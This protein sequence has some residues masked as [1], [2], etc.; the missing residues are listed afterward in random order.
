MNQVNVQPVNPFMNAA[1][2]Q[3]EEEE[4]KA[5][6]IG[7]IADHEEEVS[8]SACIEGDEAMVEVVAE[9]SYQS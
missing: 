2:R 3:A 5:N 7:N 6:I 4:C 9:P 8:H 1:P